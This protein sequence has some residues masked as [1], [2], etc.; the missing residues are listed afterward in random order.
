[1][2]TRYFVCLFV[3]VLIGSVSFSQSF[4][5]EEAKYYFGQEKYSI[6]QSMFDDIYSE[7]Y[8]DEALFFSAYCSKMLFSS[9]AEYR[10]H[11][12]LDEFPYSSFRNKTTETKGSYR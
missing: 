11:V 5:L 4:S 2:F 3:C 7:E 12:F 6:A 8:S 10:F 9:D 1:M